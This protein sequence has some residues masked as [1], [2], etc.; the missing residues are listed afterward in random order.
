[1]TLLG[2]L[3]VLFALKVIEAT[4]SSISFGPETPRTRKQRLTDEMRT[5]DVVILVVAGCAALIF[6]A[7]VTVSLVRKY[8]RKSLAPVEPLVEAL[9]D[10]VIIKTDVS[11]K[12]EV[13][14]SK[15][16]NWEDVFGAV[17]VA[18]LTGC[19]VAFLL[20]FNED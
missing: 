13:G 6:A 10:D 16:R 14:T 1:M 8:R 17:G 12:P 11:G 15:T 5:S 2:G 3:L 18:L 7:S 9:D 4:S 20:N 19:L